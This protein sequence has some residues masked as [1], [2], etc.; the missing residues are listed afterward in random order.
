MENVPATMFRP[1]S[2]SI[3]HDCARECARL[4]RMTDDPELRH[5]LFEIARRWMALA[6]EEENE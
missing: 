2:D 1:A 6:M 5:E 4:G 3:C